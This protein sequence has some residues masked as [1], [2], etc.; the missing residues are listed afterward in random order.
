[1]PSTRVSSI[2]IKS[3]PNPWLAGVLV[4]FAIGAAA[5]QPSLLGMVVAMATLVTVLL[6]LVFRTRAVTVVFEKKEAVFHRSKLHPS[7][8]ENVVALAA[9]TRVYAT[10]FSSNSGWSIHL[11]GPTGEHLLLA[12]IPSPFQFGK[13]NPAIRDLCSQIALGLHVVDGGGG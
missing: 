8:P 3:P 12:R 2:T 10:S 13:Q 9:F 1:M 11:S 5:V 7:G 6:W 4:F